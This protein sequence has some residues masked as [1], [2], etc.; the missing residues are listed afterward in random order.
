MFKM[1]LFV[2]TASSH[3]PSCACLTARSVHCFFNRAFSSA[4]CAWV[5]NASSSATDRN[6][7]LSELIIAQQCNPARTTPSLARYAPSP[8]LRAEQYEQAHQGWAGERIPVYWRGCVPS[9]AGVRATYSHPRPEPPLR[10]LHKTDLAQGR[11]GPVHPP[12]RAGAA[13]SPPPGHHPPSEPP[14]FPDALSKRPRVLHRNECVQEDRAYT[15]T[16]APSRRRS[17]R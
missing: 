13:S 8:C 9:T 2:A 11:S 7:K 16:P 10:D 3:K 5:I 14:P 1:F 6:V 15:G 12:E 17:R 4:D